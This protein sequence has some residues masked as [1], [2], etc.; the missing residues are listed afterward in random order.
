M[1]KQQQQPE[2][3]RQHIAARPGTQAP[4]FTH[5]TAVASH[6]VADIVGYSF[7]YA[8]GDWVYGSGT[9]CWEGVGGCLLTA[10]WLGVG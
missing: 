8:G 6:I 2:D 7:A 3:N 9:P 10:V 1:P 5:S 4:K